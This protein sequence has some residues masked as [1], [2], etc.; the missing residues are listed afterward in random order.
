M[1]KERGERHRADG[2]H[3]RGDP[4]PM[5]FAPEMRAGRPGAIIEDSVRTMIAGHGG[6]EIVRTARLFRLVGL[7]QLVGYAGQVAV[8]QPRGEAVGDD[9]PGRSEADVDL[10]PGVI[11][12]P[13][14]GIRNPLRPFSLPRK[15]GYSPRR[16]EVLG[17]SR[18]SR[19]HFNCGAGL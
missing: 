10:A 1:T 14:D 5:L 3:A 13:D 15:I 16:V 6:E 12:R 2:G 8:Q 17:I 7:L 18:S 19:Y 9:G 11:G 4:S